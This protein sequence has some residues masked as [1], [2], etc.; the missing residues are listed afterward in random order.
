MSGGLYAAGGYGSLKEYIDAAIP[1]GR[2]QAFKALRIARNHARET[3]VRVGIE[4][5]D[6]WLTF[7][8]LSPEDD[9]PADIL[10]ATIMVDGVRIP[11]V[12][13]TTAQLEAANAALRA[14]GSPSL[15]EEGRK[16]HETLTAALAPFAGA[17]AKV[18]ADLTVGFSGF[19]GAS[20]CDF[21]RALDAA[22]GCSTTRS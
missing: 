15:S 13:A 12:E 19:A 2:T 14:T 16:L 7:I 21:A 10:R 11:V 3:V 18:S 6:L 8:K 9:V 22:L 4:I 5:C 20:L 1:V 17:Q